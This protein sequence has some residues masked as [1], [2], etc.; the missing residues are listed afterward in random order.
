ERQN[1]DQPCPVDDDKAIGS[2]N[3][4]SAAEGAFHY[5][6]KRKQKRRYGDR[7]DREDQANFL[8][9]QI[10]ENQSAEFHATPPAIAAS[11][12]AEPSTSTPFSR[13]SVVCAR[14]A[15]TGSCVTIK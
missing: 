7:A 4:F 9:K 5:G 6:K 13:C 2:S 15:T 11:R 1:L 8:A 3:F 10:C 12:F 14:A